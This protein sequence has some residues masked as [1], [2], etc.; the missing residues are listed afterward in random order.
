MGRL[1]SA[2][3]SK[4]KID[5]FNQSAQPEGR[6]DP[7]IGSGCKRQQQYRQPIHSEWLSDRK[8]F[9]E[10]EMTM[11]SYVFSKLI[12]TNQKKPI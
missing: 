5:R 9:R 10:I 2:Y 11:K 1:Q 7:T 3:Q 12:S 4:A 8:A 6:V